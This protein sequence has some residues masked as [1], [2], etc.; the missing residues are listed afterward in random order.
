MNKGIQ[1]FLCYH[2]HKIV[3]TR[4]VCST[5]FGLSHNWTNIELDKFQKTLELPI[6]LQIPHALRKY[7]IFFRVPSKP[8]QP[9]VIEITAQFMKVIWGACHTDGGSKILG[10]HVERKER[11]AVLWSRINTAVLEKQEITVTELTEV[12]SIKLMLTVT[13]WLTNAYLSHCIL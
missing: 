3:E 10:Y 13:S 7:K 6:F 5:V 2:K 11:N 9:E 8:P 12:S 1:Q 4:Q